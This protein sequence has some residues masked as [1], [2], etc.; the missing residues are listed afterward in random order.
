L[1]LGYEE[2][3]GIPII[4]AVSLGLFDWFTIGVQ[5]GGMWFNKKRRMIPIKT[6]YEQEGWI[7][8]TNEPATVKKGA[9][10]HIDE[11]I[12]LDHII[13]GFSVIVGFSHDH[14]NQS[15]I[16]CIEQSPIDC[17]IANSDDRLKPWTMTAF[18]FLFE[19]DFATFEHPNAPH[20]AFTVDK[21]IHGKRVF[22]SSLFGASC[23]VDW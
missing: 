19:F 4:V 13:G 10:W 12:K 20:I 21:V 8:L 2:H 11:Y 3:T 14:A 5:T 18:N 17:S 16:T 7:R 15:Y 6:A 9:I 23:S 1:P 22:D